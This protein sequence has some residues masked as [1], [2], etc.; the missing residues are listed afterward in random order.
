MRRSAARGWARPLAGLAAGAVLAT[1]TP[2]TPAHPA[3]VPAA[4]SS[5]ATGTASDTATGDHAVRVE[6]RYAIAADAPRTVETG[7][8]FRIVGTAV[9]RPR[10]GAARPRPVRLTERTGGRW[11]VVAQTRTTRAGAFAFRVAA[12]ETPTSRRFRA[13]ATAYRTL[14]AATTAR[15]RVRVQPPAGTAGPPPVGPTDPWTPQAPPPAAPAPPG[16][17]D[18]DAPEPLPAGY[19]GAGTAGDWSYLFTGGSRWDP[20]RVI[21]WAYNPNAQG[22]PA[23]P[24]VQRAFAKISGAS[25]LRFRYVGET[26]YREIG[27]DDA[28]FPATADIVVGWASAAEWSRLE[29]TVVGIG[30]GQGGRVSGADVAYR[31][32]RG[33]LTL[34]NGHPLT[35]G[36]D[37]SGWGQV[38]LHEVLHALGLGHAR[39]RVQLMYGSASRDNVRFG[40]GDLTGMQ[41]VG[42]APGCL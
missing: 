14:R 25:G 26:G 12:G 33:Y 29:G 6:R 19:V 2:S 32:R 36:F 35:P 24:D 7:A 42:A 17:T 3:P 38:I 40:A 34:D 21:P 27:L 31:M 39:E 4:A 41:N 16:P 28:G 18:P 23:L 20:C 1:T 30:G 9:T 11:R 22:Y 10:S 15:I 13:Q 5:A 8:T 37:Q